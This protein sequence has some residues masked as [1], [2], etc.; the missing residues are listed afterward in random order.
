METHPYYK[1]RKDLIKSVGL[2]AALLFAHLEN[3]QESFF[4]D[5]DFY[6]QQHRMS[7]DLSLSKHQISVATQKLIDAELIETIHING[8]KKQYRILTGKESLPLLEE[9]KTRK[10][11]V[12]SNSGKESKPLL[13]E[14][15]K[16]SLPLAVKN[17]NR[18]D[19][20]SNLDLDLSTKDEKQKDPLESITHERTREELIEERM[21]SFLEGEMLNESV[22]EETKEKSVI[23]NS[24]PK[25]PV[26]DLSP[27]ML[28]FIHEFE[29]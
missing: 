7:K 25:K 6:Q 12:K 16:E 19:E 20:D 27:K 11:K 4:K 9:S 22:Y 21:N 2:E 15:S 23:D 26:S 10:R 13:L 3:L 8:Q 14:S 29:Y 24:V 28:Q 5:I 1:V 17:L 18:E